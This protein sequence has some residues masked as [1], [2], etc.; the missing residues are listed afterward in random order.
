MYH[1]SPRKKK[2]IFV[3]VLLLLMF[4]FVEACC[5]FLLHFHHRR[6]SFVKLSVEQKQLI[7]LIVSGKSTRLRYSQTL[8]WEPRPGFSDATYQYNRHGARSQYDY[9]QECSVEKM[10]VL[11]FGDSYTHC[12][13]VGNDE[14]WQFEITKLFPQYEIINFGVSGYGLDQAYLRYVQKKDIYRGAKVVVIGYMTENINRSE[15]VFRPFYQTNTKIPLAK[16]RFQLINDE[17][18]LCKNP[19]SLVD[20]NLLVTK[21]L[22][23]LSKLGQNDFF[24]MNCYQRGLLDVLPSVRLLKTRWHTRQ[25]EFYHSSSLDLLCRIFQKFHREVKKYGAMPVIVI[26]P[27]IY[28]IKNLPQGKYYQP[29][30]SRLDKLQYKYIDIAEAFRD[31][32]NPRKYFLQAHYNNLGNRI[33]AEAIAKFIERSIK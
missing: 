16:P 2:V 7:P 29:L 30:L 25:F 15:N 11:C 27:N 14:T 3:T 26:F 32:E 5:F 19:L 9:T 28:D 22:P 18:V 20:Y 12:D 24:Y 6:P 1:L 23:T 17:L 21:P 33:V 31:V 13:E 4:I 8:G 10:R